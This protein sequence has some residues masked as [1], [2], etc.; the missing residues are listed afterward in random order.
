MRWS[1]EE[2]VLELAKA[3]APHGRHYQANLRRQG[4]HSK[5]QLPS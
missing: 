2:E 4:Q 1:T 3:V 5:W